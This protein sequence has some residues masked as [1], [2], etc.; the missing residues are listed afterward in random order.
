ML[1]NCA[2]DGH[3]ILPEF[4]IVENA[5]EAVATKDKTKRAEDD[6]AS[7]KKTGKST[8]SKAVSLPEPKVL[9]P[10]QSC[11]DKK[12]PIFTIT[13]DG[14]YT[15]KLDIQPSPDQLKSQYTVNL[16]IE[17]K[18]SYGYLS[19]ADWPFLP[20]YASMCVV[21][22]VLG[23]IWLTVSFL[24]WR[25]LLRIQFWIGGV[26]VL[27]ML[28][29]AMFLAEYQNLNLNGVPSDKLVLAAEWVSCAKRTLARMLVIIVS[30]GFG[31]VK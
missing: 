14:F 5:K 15:L 10:T 12:C 7:A 19:A 6:N 2:H 9:K 29:K 30:L 25:D 18:S 8:N 13:K 22:V 3:I 1:Y 27:G 4:K 20:F 17:M 21:Y 31:I 24:Q 23:I 11:D 16:T 26:I 28:E